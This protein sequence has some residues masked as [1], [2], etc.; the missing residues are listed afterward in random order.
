LYVDGSRGVTPTVGSSERGE[1]IF[2]KSCKEIDDP[3]EASS[4]AVA[5]AARR[6]RLSMDGCMGLA[7]SLPL[8]H[9]WAWSLAVCIAAAAAEEV[10]SATKVKL[11]FA[12][13]RV[14]RPA[15][16]LGGWFVIGAAYCV[17]FLFTL[18]SILRAPPTPIWTA[19]ALVL[20]V[21]LLAANAIWNLFFF[22]KKIFC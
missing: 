7:S 3:G 15:L 21:A 1:S 4:F 5:A 13:L 2:G 9:P 17:F 12:E 20:V 16:P 10:L 8:Q 14:P 11:R 18:K 6:S 19:T 22:R